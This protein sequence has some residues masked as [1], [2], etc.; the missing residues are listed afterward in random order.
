MGRRI[1]YLLAKFDSKTQEILSGYYD[2]LSKKG[3]VGTQN[4]DVPYHFT[5]GSFD[6]SDEEEKLKEMEAVASSTKPFDIRL[7]HIGVF[8]MNTIFIEPNMNFE[9]LEL[10]TKFFD[11]NGRG[12]HLWTAHST[13]LMDEPYNIVTALPI[14]LEEFT[15]I[16]ARIDKIGLYEF[17]P[18]S[19]IK[20]C[21]LKGD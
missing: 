7:D 21:T 20:E 4:K 3:Y 15:P 11:C 13:I 1:L 19:L 10:E 8:G 14:L 2:V 18:T 17:T 16:N 5:L 6:C 9:L 12:S